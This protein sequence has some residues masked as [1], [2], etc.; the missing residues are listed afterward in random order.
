MLYFTIDSIYYMHSSV[1][2][3]KN[4]LD[5]I[6]VIS[7]YIKLQKAGR[8][9]RANCPFHNEKT[10]S[11]FVSPERQIWHCFG[12]GKGGDIFAFV[13]EVEG[14]E[15]VD[16]LRVLA[17]QAG[18]ILKRLDSESAEWRTERQ[19]L[20]EV[21]E[22]ALKFFEK[23]LE[24]SKNGKGLKKY[25]AGRGFS[26]ETISLW[27]LGYAPDDWYALSEFFKKRGYTDDEI[28][29]SGLVVEK[30][31]TDYRLP[32]TAKKDGAAASSPSAASN[33]YDRFRNRIIFP[34]CDLNGRVVGFA[35]RVLPGDDESQAKYINVSQT[36]IYDKSRMLYGLNVAKMEI[37]AKDFCIIVEGYTDVMM[38]HQAGIKN[39]V[40]T[41]G[42]AL[43]EE[44]LKII[45]RYTE[46]LIL[47][48]DMDIAGDTATKRGIDLAI[49]NG[50]NIKIIQP[51]RNAAS[52]R[53][54]DAS[55]ADWPSVA[56]GPAKDRKEKKDPADIIKENPQSW[57]KAIDG[58]QGIIEFYFTN[59][60]SQN[61][62]QE[63]S[64]KKK[65]AKI[66]LPLLKKISDPVERA[67]W[68]QELA[69]RLRV[70]EK[71]LA[72][73]MRKTGDN[74]AISRPGPRS[75]PS[76]RS[77]KD[78]HVVLEEELVGLLCYLL[79]NTEDVRRIVEHFDIAKIEKMLTD[80]RLREIFISLKPHLNKER[81]SEGEKKN[82]DLKQWQAGLPSDLS[83]FSNQIL[84]QL[85]FQEIDN[86]VLER[87]FD[88]CLKE[89]KKE[90]IKQKMT[91]LQYEIR[92]LENTKD[93]ERLNELSKAFRGLAK[94]LLE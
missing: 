19:R 9:F 79:E 49:A 81:I 29:K 93:K 4:K 10:P 2:E 15:F 30:T 88:K 24:A 54:A 94:E 13:K 47:A 26:A 28:I 1:D 85:E 35:G 82:F 27:R 84:F 61:N 71:L 25:L 90:G 38:S 22:L 83:S 3:I 59:T 34:L 60:F 64:G 48:F 31:T 32:T 75:Q 51:A 33:Y 78:R 57:L 37:R 68:I 17:Q 52:A 72:E 87:Y 7:G 16:A 36:P 6:E 43:T 62:C 92:E 86:T 65:I 12:C 66:L 77:Q 39:T 91:R 21:C 58:A 74:D 42:T 20:Y 69:K 40:A 67:H 44:Q 76:K 14:V 89:L 41:S 73:A 11:F 80:N 18:V 8:N 5:V 56:G 70:Q 50:F 53:H 55:H 46:N 63:P 23:Q 45:R